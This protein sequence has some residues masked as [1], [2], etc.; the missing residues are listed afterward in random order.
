VSYVTLPF[1][2]ILHMRG[3]K[4]HVDQTKRDKQRPAVLAKGGSKGKMFSDQAAGPQRAGITG[5]TPNPAPGAKA[6]KGG[7][8]ESKMRFAEPA[9]SGRAGPR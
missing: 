2:E 6:A 9:R 1:W 7:K 4:L 5:G 3:N 8:L